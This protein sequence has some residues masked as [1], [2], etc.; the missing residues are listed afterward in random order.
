MVVG[1]TV[2]VN[3][4][5]ITKKKFVSFFHCWRFYKDIHDEN[6]NKGRVLDEEIIGENDQTME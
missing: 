6:D 2:V 5:K 3:S 4:Q 1:D